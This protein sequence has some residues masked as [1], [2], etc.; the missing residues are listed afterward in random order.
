MIF[1]WP[2]RSSKL[3]SRSTTVSS[4]DSET[5]SKTMIRSSGPVGLSIT[6]LRDCDS[7]MSIKQ[8]NHQARDEKIEHEH[9]DRCRDDSVRRRTADALRA[10]FGAQ[11]YMTTDADD[12]KP[13]EE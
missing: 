3:T 2:R 9:G 7:S 5:W 8:T 11:P 1:V 13:Q 4:N 10:S 6:A 12:R